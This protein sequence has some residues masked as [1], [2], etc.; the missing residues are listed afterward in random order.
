MLRG[1]IF[2]KS[3]APITAPIY[4]L[5]EGWCWAASRRAESRFEESDAGG[6]ADV[7]DTGGA[8]AAY[9]SE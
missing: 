9:R 1:D 6:G 5:L 2:K 8:P 7:R 3:W 4:A